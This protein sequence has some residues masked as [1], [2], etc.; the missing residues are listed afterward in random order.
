MRNVLILTG[1]GIFLGFGYVSVLACMCPGV[2][3]EMYPP[4][5]K[6]SREY[7]KKEFNGAAF[8]G[9]VMSS[10]EA[11]DVLREGQKVQELTVEIDR[12]WFGVDRRSITIYT[13]KDG[14]GCWL[15]FLKNESYF[16]IPTLV[17]GRLHVEICAYATF[18][19]KHDGNYVAF[20]V[21]MFGKGKKFD[22]KR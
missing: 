16:F 18:N 2:N 5:V 15:P 4:D 6:K 11:P 22:V 10:E 9:K 8:T 14:S 1:L 21:K 19:R 12:Y 3:P 20:M 13:P 7:Y 17:D